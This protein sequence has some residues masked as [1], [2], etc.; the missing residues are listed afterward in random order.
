MTWRPIETAPKDGYEFMAY[1]PTG[2]PQMVCI[3]WLSL[4]EWSGWVYADDVLADISAPEPTHWW[5]FG[6]GATM[7]PPPEAD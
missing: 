5:D 4:P 7:P 2:A 1:E 3:L 6:D